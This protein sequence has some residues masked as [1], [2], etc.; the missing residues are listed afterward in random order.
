[1]ASI[2]HIASGKLN[3]QVH[4][5]CYK[6]L[7]MAHFL[8][9]LKKN[10]QKTNNQTKRTKT[11]GISMCNSWRCTTAASLRSWGQVRAL[12]SAASPRQALADLTKDGWKQRQLHQGLNKLFLSLCKYCTSKGQGWLLQT[13]LGLERRQGRSW[14]G[15]EGRTPPGQ[16]SPKGLQ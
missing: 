9:I 14:A 1:M 5:A 16:G 8:C 3:S 15:G 6:I 13:P 11:P 2:P 7:G 12:G 4:Q 10:Q